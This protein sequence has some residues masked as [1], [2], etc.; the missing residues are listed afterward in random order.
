M[1][2]AEKSV[3]VQGEIWLFEI[4]F[5][6]EGFFSE[7]G[8]DRIVRFSV[9]VGNKTLGEVL[10][11]IL[12]MVGGPT[13]RLDPPWNV[14]ESIRLDS[15]AFELELRNGKARYGFSYTDL[16]IDL[17]FA[18]LDK[19]EVFYA[20]KDSQVPNS[21]LDVNL[22]GKFL[23]IDFT[24]QPISW[25]A[26]REQPP[27]APAA[28][29]K[30]LKIDY[31]GLGQRVTL[32][33]ILTLETIGA[34][35]TALRNSYQRLS[36]ETLNPLAD[37][38]PA[39][40]Y[41]ESAAWLVGAQFS[42]LE[43]FDFSGLWNLPKLAGARIGL[44][45][46]R[47]KSLAGFQFEILYRRIAAD[48]GQYSMELVLP[49]V[50][51][52]FQAGAASV[53]LPIIAVEIYT[54]GGFKIDLGYPK[55]LNFERSFSIEM[56]IGPVPVTGAI[57][58]YFGRLSA[59]AVPNLPAIQGGSFGPVIIAGVG[60]RI[61]V[62]KSFTAG[63]LS[64]GIFIGIEGLIEGVLGFYEPFE[65]SEPK[66]TFYRVSG[67]LALTGH[68]Y[69]KVDFAIISAAVDV[70]AYV[71]VQATFEAYRATLLLFEA[72][73]SV[74]LTVKVGWG[75]FSF[76]VG[77]S[78][79]ATIRE[80]V[81]I[82]QDQ[83]APWQIT[84]SVGTTIK[85]KLGP[86]A[87]RRLP[88]GEV[89]ADAAFTRLADPLFFAARQV[90]I[91]RHGLNPFILATPAQPEVLELYF[92]PVTA[93]GIYH[94][95]PDATPDPTAAEVTLVA[96]LTA[97][98][99]RVDGERYSP[100]E[101][102]A[103]TVLRWGLSKVRELV[104]MAG[105]EGDAGRVTLSELHYL[106]DHIQGAQ[107]PIEITPKAIREFFTEWVA[108]KLVPGD[109]VSEKTALTP[110]PMIPLLTLKAG[111]GETE[112]YRRDFE[113]FAKCTPEYRANIR[114]YFED[115]D[116]MRVPQE[117]NAAI[118]AALDGE[119]LSMASLVF[120]D[121]FRLVLRKIVADAIEALDL[122][123]VAAAGRTLAAIA[124][125]CG[126]GNP[127]GLER[128]IAA[129]LD[130]K[131][132]FAAGANIAMAANGVPLEPGL[133]LADLALKFELPTLRAAR[134][135]YTQPLIEPNAEIPLS[136]V[137]H[138][139]TA[140]D[141]R[142][143]IV[144]RYN[145]QHWNQVLE[146]NPLFDWQV[147]AAV[148]DS[149]YPTLELPAGSWIDIPQF[150]HAAAP[151]QSLATLAERY[152]LSIVSLIEGTAA[153]PLTGEGLARQGIT[154]NVRAGETIAAL[155]KRIGAVSSDEVARD[156]LDD[157]LILAAGGTLNIPAGSHLIARGETLNGIAQ[158][159]QI[160]PEA[161]A[162]ANADALW[163]LIP[164]PNTS[165]SL[166]MG[167]KLALPAVAAFQPGLNDTFATVARLFELEPQ[168]LARANAESFVLPTLAEV[169][170]PVM[171]IATGEAP[172]SPI[173]AAQPYAIDP[174]GLTRANQGA[175]SGQGA[176]APLNIVLV[177]ECEST[178]ETRLIDLLAEGGTASP[179][180]VATQSQARFILAGLRLPA[181]DGTAMSA[182]P[183]VGELLYPLYTL[184]G[185]QWPAPAT[186][187]EQ[188]WVELAWNQSPPAL[189][190]ARA[191]N[192]ELPPPTKVYLKPN[193]ITLI[194]DFRT[195]SSDPAQIQ[196][197]ILA[198]TPFPAFQQV[199][200][201][202]VFG[203][204]TPWSVAQP[205]QFI[206]GHPGN[207]AQLPLLL[208]VPEGMRR[209]LPANNAKLAPLVI[210]ET[211]PDPVTGAPTSR[212]LTNVGWGTR[213]D[214]EIRRAYG[215]P[216]G[217][218]PLP[219]TYEAVGI[220]AQGQAD[221]EGLRAYIGRE[222]TTN[223]IDL[224]LL[225]ESDDLGPVP[226]TLR[227]D[228]I[229]KADR[230]RV[231][232]IKSNLS[233]FSN[234]AL[235]RQLQSPETLAAATLAEGVE[236]L[237]LL[238]QISVTNGGGFFLDYPVAPDGAGL[239]ESLFAA[240]EGATVSILAVLRRAAGTEATIDP[241]RF[242]NVLVT[243]E[244]L[245]GTT[246]TVRATASSRHV[247]AVPGVEPPIS[248]ALGAIAAAV[249]VTVAELAALNASNGALLK[250]GAKVVK[251]EG[252]EH[253]V[254]PGDDLLSV[255]IALELG[256]RELADRIQTQ[257]GLL[258]L[259]A[260]VEV[261]PGWFSG[262]SLVQPD[263]GGLRVYR[264][265]PVEPAQFT[266]R[267]D[268][269]DDA[270]FR[271]QTLFQLMGYSLA[272]TDDFTASRKGLPILP[273]GPE[274]APVP[275]VYRR[276]LPIS[277][278]AEAERFDHL[279]APDPYAGLG[280]SPKVEFGFQDVFGN[281]LPRATAAEA[282]SWTQ[283]YRDPLVPL[284]AWPSVTL[285]YDVDYQ[286][287]WNA[288]RIIIRIKFAPAGYA[289]TIGVTQ[290][291]MRQRVEADQRRFA[292]IYYQVANERV[293]AN[294]LTTLT[295]NSPA[296]I[297]SERLARFAADA[298]HYF[299]ALLRL[300]PD[301]EKLT[302][303][304]T[305]S[306]L[307]KV[308]HVLVSEMA[309]HLANEPGMLRVGA[310]LVVP[311]RITVLP[312][313]SLDDISATTGGELGPGEI[314]LM[315]AEVLLTPG[316]N[317]VVDGSEHL[318]ISGDTL[319]RIT[320]VGGSV[321]KVAIDNRS[322]KGLFIEGSLLS[323]GAT[324]AEVVPGDTLRSIADARAV[325]LDLLAVAN[326]DRAIFATGAQA[327]L[328]LH[329][330]IPDGTGSTAKVGSGQSLSEFVIANGASIRDVLTANSATTKLLN[331]G[332]EL[333]YR[334]SEKD[335]EF[336]QE[337]LPG[338]TFAT[339]TLRFARDIKDP[340]LKAADVGAY[341]ANAN[342]K[343]L[344]VGGALMLLPPVRF[345]KDVDV[346]RSA[347]RGVSIDQLGVEIEIFRNDKK[348][349]DPAFENV[350]EVIAV[351]STVPARLSSAYTLDERATLKSFARQFQKTFTNLKLCAGPDVLTSI[352]SPAQLGDESDVD[353]KLVA[354]HWGKNG[355]DA[356]V[357]GL[358][359]FFAPRPLLNRPWNAENVPIRPYIPGQS[360]DFS[361]GA[362]AV[363]TTFTGVDLERWAG[364][365]L[366]RIDR[367]LK[368]DLALPLRSM[369][370][371]DFQ[372]IIDAKAAIANAVAERIEL[373]LDPPAG[374][375][376]DRNAAAE[377]LKQQ[378]L[379]ELGA[380]YRGGVVIQY[381][382]EATAPDGGWTR[383]TAPRLLGAVAPVLPAV[384]AAD[385]TLDGL[386]RSLDA[387]ALLVAEMVRNVGD[388]L[389]V[390]F[391][392]EIHGV[393]ITVEALDTIERVAERAKVDLETLVAA[394][395]DVKGFLRPLAE[396][397][398]S[399]RK[400]FTDVDDS[401]GSVLERLA[402][403]LTS[404]GLVDQAI[405]TF[406]SMNGKRDKVFV[407]GVVLEWKGKKHT[408][409]AKDT[410]LS[411]ADSLGAPPV[412][413]YDSYYITVPLIRPQTTFIFLSRIPPVTISATKIALF[414][415]AGNT[416][417]TVFVTTT[418]DEASNVSLGLRFIAE[419][420]E[421]NIHDVAGEG[422]YQGSEWLTF[423]DFEFSQDLNTPEV[424]VVEVPVPNRQFPLPPQ[425]LS[426]GVKSA[427]TSDNLEELLRYDYDLQFAFDAATQDELEYSRWS[428]PGIDALLKERALGDEENLATLL[429]QYQ[430]IDTP[431]WDQ[432]FRLRSLA[433]N[434]VGEE[435]R[436]I[437]AKAVE[438]FADLALRIGAAW[439]N[440]KGQLRPRADGQRFR[441]HRHTHRDGRM[442]LT[443]TG[444]KTTTGP[445]GN[446]LLPK[447]RALGRNYSYHLTPHMA[448]TTLAAPWPIP[449][450]R[451]G[452]YY[453]V[454]DDGLNLLETQICLG[455]ISVSRNRRL[456]NG[457]KTREQF[458]LQ[459][460][461]VRAVRPLTPSFSFT[462]RIDGGGGIG[463][464]AE[465]LKG[466]IERIY[467]PKE[468]TS[469]PQSQRVS[470]TAAFARRIA[471]QEGAA[472]TPDDRTTMFAPVATTPLLTL[473][474]KSGEPSPTPA[475]LAEKLAKYLNDEMTNRG[476]PSRH[477][478]SLTFR[479]FSSTGDENVP[480]RLLEI[481]DLRVPMTDH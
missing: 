272:E 261:R 408:T 201:E 450:T 419:A 60:F 464:L 325:D 452:E 457:A 200:L 379:V 474:N 247:N 57:G 238:W 323:L 259:G 271:I 7:Q 236:F 240:G 438:I 156:L 162:Q 202:Q 231:V 320:P 420:L 306:S 470:I 211:M 406:L 462:Y 109:D 288:P 133:T 307:S 377:Q 43:A 304:S 68:I 316:L 422:K 468:R 437:I 442:L 281:R 212:V 72:G 478:W 42:V 13:L 283:L 213:I 123:S 383:D 118:E 230:A 27:Q 315:N 160:S 339:I 95:R 219:T 426:H 6:L 279:P 92:W 357:E 294:V 132:L 48:L 164:R 110:F 232:L 76:K 137:R 396:V 107:P 391:K 180:A 338:D 443:V 460:P 415:G 342:N 145:L 328:P 439:A 333:T 188:Y 305:L 55:N 376:P 372:R 393:K 449:R 86:V 254:A 195:L 432:V 311:E 28:T 17:T 369:S 124:A 66:A 187:N 472:V 26:L 173:A 337:V 249:G 297:D 22:F 286:P 62:G 120:F 243:A 400:V 73:V 378:L 244:N 477:D 197:V 280:L 9:R 209:L 398:L 129:N 445:D 182:V 227:S 87:Y 303:K 235:L 348:L 266:T 171:S 181:T 416:M 161:I 163:K 21:S 228:A 119:T 10:R 277:P 471:E 15:F 264:Q 154:V 80:Q 216:T 418:P 386:A 417:N 139:I 273:Q 317:L 45:G 293:D 421:Y 433:E 115:L 262:E 111:E 98:M 183:G 117:G 314:G 370:P 4:P 18:Q 8:T 331:A 14:I 453:E 198:R 36:D 172:P 321:E 19:L 480:P 101:V 397:P 196:A 141:T 65:R 175:A 310:K 44:R 11:Y 127:A 451:R 401:I 96:N 223:P 52:R 203:A 431:L 135:I 344:L 108:P 265:Q 103:A 434:P 100:A 382:V 347:V 208:D 214:I 2:T 312:N 411:V 394:L 41:D 193:D 165:E 38:L 257:Q 448:V 16:G 256:L 34:V 429:A 446:A 20:P 239:P 395:H 176:S 251:S 169:T 270:K 350:P 365:L 85:D 353:S 46:E 334:Q 436:K 263:Q 392:F 225:Y 409:T 371:A 189:A 258:V 210:A 147:P 361:P 276:L 346:A 82:G 53:T 84:A 229:A 461:D 473:S 260:K 292:L 122:L 77:L 404:R 218:D 458:V 194:T 352:P 184:S 319:S 12:E 290:A 207:P 49:D 367:V 440:W 463:P 385:P 469:I 148:P 413:F 381:K 47:V 192:A 341:P 59:K 178:E 99:S 168:A 363:L 63:I 215:S 250:V 284:H 332:Q 299:A 326:A 83:R 128:I 75:I 269:I 56:M 308:A 340:S 366:S 407:E 410:L 105:G 301:V 479:L 155:A 345:G 140:D 91:E 32:R 390:G 136:G 138:F 430:A 278:F 253:V 360:L 179:L 237:D 241:A 146:A 300:E 204:A 330:T 3:T 199:P 242:H 447:V 324:E 356:R 282:V 186:P 116:P 349:I 425:I 104:W 221:L 134:A 39:L 25:D 51:R 234:P 467:F 313:R 412:E 54:D 190:M 114:R 170:L 149:H 441:I 384:P 50:L 252:N 143:E 206:D 444:E 364:L 185:Q 205:V 153:I 245:T 403:N 130:N 167:V 362:D 131:Q 318:T 475:E 37:H 220:D 481:T 287:E 456:V 88:T 248:E 355:F 289:A 428:P 102:Y 414:P 150:N 226:E 399:A 93:L 374:V 30:I 255:A 424:R 274:E 23:G 354:V 1:T 222:Q 61:G 224:Y 90:P 302:E 233:T 71:S 112:Q 70:Y 31:L 389:K 309:L 358:P 380:T 435:D 359:V 336:T 217:G 368:P 58:I 291:R 121:C 296:A 373:V 29:D 35:V 268:A 351:A 159:L 375:T 81:L 106:Q 40:T 142:T 174:D 387:D 166:P 322:V 79:S 191:A 405:K 329:L 125:D 388:L 158:R 327:E 335:P 78:F 402:P 74:N 69:G 89:V 64:A 94:D 151:N 126:M 298:W 423:V 67:C 97:R 157:P 33:D 459:V 144:A 427:A 465:R 152:G 275:W 454:H 113:L 5:V 24:K 177:P 246:A 285:S 455:G 343:Q 267:A 295:P 466:V 476:I